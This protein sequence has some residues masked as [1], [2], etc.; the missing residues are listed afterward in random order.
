DVGSV[1]QPRDLNPDASFV[2]YDSQRRHVKWVRY[3]YPI[4]D[5]QR[6]IHACHLPDY[7]ADRLKAGR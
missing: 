4:G 2:L 3:H 1:G 6:K 5:V 7:L